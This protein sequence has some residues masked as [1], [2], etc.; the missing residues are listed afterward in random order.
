MVAVELMQLLLKSRCRIVG[1]CVFCVQLIIFLRRIG[2][3]HGSGGMDSE[4]LETFLTV[5]RRGGVSAAANELAR[6]QSA[7]SRRL[8][9]LEREAGVPL[10]ERIGR[11]MVLS[12][13]GAALLPYAERVA[14]ALDDAKSAVTAARSGAAG[15]VRLVTVGTLAGDP[16]SAALRRVK[17]RFT[18]LDL[19]LQTATSAEVSAK[20]RS[21]EATL[22]LRYFEDRSPEIDC[23]VVHEERLVVACAIRHP[24]AGK[25]LK[26]L[27]RL[28]GE[29]W[30]SF[31]VQERRS[32]AFAATVFAQFLTRGIADIDWIAID[33]LTAQKRL[34]EGGFGLALLQASAIGEELAGR[35]LAMIRVND[36]KVKIPVALVRRRGSFLGV[37]SRALMAE[38]ERLRPDRR[39]A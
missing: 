2:S 18:G 4:A 31:P 11:K 24:L 23:R 32:E 17:S 5:H 16:L 29:R 21:G 30:L 37:G 13:A 6:T 35:R 20:V 38:L 22:G 19:R 1:Q 15:T 10:F 33:S 14:A 28:A 9:L 36:L 3:L 8:A 34:V 27:T 26:S 39:S 7:I 12:D 25:R